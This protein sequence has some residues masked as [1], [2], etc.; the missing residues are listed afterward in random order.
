MFL[1]VVVLA[2]DLSLAG[3]ADRSIVGKRE[4]VFDRRAYI[5]NYGFSRPG[6]M[7]FDRCEFTKDHMIV[8]Y[9]N[10]RLEYVTYSNVS[11]DA[12]SLEGY[13]VRYEFKNAE[14]HFYCR[15]TEAVFV[16]K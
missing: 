13:T 1:F 6:E 4:C 2:T 11:D 14:L 9:N 7:G 12:I 10:G 5:G 8:E 16:R 3:C 15:D